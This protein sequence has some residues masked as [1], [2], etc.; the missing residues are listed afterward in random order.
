[1]TVPLL[2]Q[3]VVWPVA[4]SRQP[5]MT[6]VVVVLEVIVVVVDAP[7]RGAHRSFATLGVTGAAAELIGSR[8]R[9]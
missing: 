6:V 8:E 1:M 7:A 5:V 4:G 9:G 2:S 3:H